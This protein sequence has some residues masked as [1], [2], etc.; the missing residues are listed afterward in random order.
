MDALVGKHEDMPN[1]CRAERMPDETLDVI[2]LYDT[3]VI[4]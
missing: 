3:N 2:S 1:L 4:R